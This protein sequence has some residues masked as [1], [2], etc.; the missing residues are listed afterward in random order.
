MD[1]IRN[2]H[3]EGS[4]DSTPARLTDREIDEKLNATAASALAYVLPNGKLYGR[5]YHCGDVLDSRPKRGSKG[6]FKFNISKLAGRDFGPTGEERGYAGVFSVYVGHHRG[7]RGAARRAA[8]DFLGLSETERPVAQVGKGSRG[9]G[10][11][12]TWTQI[13]PAP[14]IPP[15]FRKLVWDGYRYSDCWPYNDPS[16]RGLFHVLRMDQDVV[17]PETGEVTTEKV[18]PVVSFGHFA[19][20]CRHWRTKGAGLNILF[21]L[22]ELARR[23]HVPVL[24]VEGEKAAQVA[25]LLFPDWVVITWK[26]GCS[27]VGKIDFTP[28]KGRIVYFLADADKQGVAAMETAKKRAAA[29]GAV[30]TTLA[31]PPEAC[32]TAKK[33]WDLADEMPD[34]WTVDRMRDYI[35]T[36]DTWA[37]CGLPAYYNA[38][39]MPARDARRLQAKLI[40][41]FIPTEVEMIVARE[42]ARQRAEDESSKNANLTPAQKAQ[43][44]KRHK[45]DVA[46]MLGLESL[47]NGHRM[48][49]TGSQ[50]T[51]KSS[52]AL[53]A[54]AKLNIPWLRIVFTLPTVEKSWEAARQYNGYRRANSL[55]AY[56]VRGRGAFADQPNEQGIRLTDTR[57]CA[58]HK[59]VNRAASMRLSPRKTICPTCPFRHNCEALKQE[60]ELAEFSGGVFFMAREYVFLDLPVDNVHL[61]IGDESLTAVAASEPVYIDPLRIA[62]VGNWKSKGINAAVDAMAVLGSVHKAVTQHSG[63]ILAGCRELNVGVQDLRKVAAYL[64][65]VREEAVNSRVTGEMSD[66]QIET[67]LDDIQRLEFGS[68]SR[69]CRQLAIEVTQPR[70]QANTVCLR[71]PKD[72][73]TGEVVDRLAVFHLRKLR[74]SQEVPILLLDGTGSPWLNRKVFGDK[75]IHHHVPIERSAVVMSTLGRQFSRQ[76]VTG[77]DRNDELISEAVTAEVATLRR[78]IVSFAASL[79]QSVFVCAT[80]RAETA[81]E[82]EVAAAREAGVDI[83]TAHFA[84]VRGKN[85][86]QHYPVAMLIGREEVTPWAL[87]DMTRPFLGDD[88]ELLV[89][90]V[91]DDGRSCYVKQCRGRR[92]RDGTVVPVEVS[93]HPDPR[94]EDMHEQVREAELLQALD[95]VRAIYNH[96]TVYL[97]NHLVLDVTYD[98]NLSWRDMKAGGTRFDVA[99]E[100]TGRSVFLDAPGEWNRCFPD[101]WPTKNAAKCAIR[102][103][104]VKLPIVSIESPYNKLL[105]NRPPLCIRYQRP[106]QGQQPCLAW[107]CAPAEKACATLEKVVGPILDTWSIDWAATVSMQALPQVPAPL[108]GDEVE[109]DTGDDVETYADLLG[110]P[111]AVQEP[112]AP[113]AL[114]PARV[115]NASSITIRPMEHAAFASSITI[116][117]MEHAALVYVEP[118]EDVFHRQQRATHPWPDRNI[119]VH[120]LPDSNGLYWSDYEALL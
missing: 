84:D 35:V 82:A 89:P 42:T 108:R 23:P 14:A 39:A 85:R 44:T 45:R 77:T 38:P 114:S 30:R 15:D 16:G 55:P 41:E 104:G 56:V 113:P 57:M 10:A 106:G 92:M 94:C 73:D 69:L 51:G 119:K 9:H 13:F 117:P 96:R 31:T 74:V 28:L 6:S 120:E 59:T 33:G 102:E 75:L 101:L 11:D 61:L 7:D 12:E 110:D 115:A 112:V 48:L 24:V 109:D 26:G 97:L 32:W 87:E 63:S 47:R 8:L 78:D 36:S 76:S 2:R 4:A 66:E 71:H 27:N 100:R 86:W 83:A 90:S 72:K 91:D 34:G 54:I 37:A 68:V 107:V 17:D 21:G 88:P 99:F 29:A 46:R 64:D 58:R 118:E 49:I 65:D 3:P 79:K 43:I 22:D 98:A 52:D 105:G 19:D 95:R 80:M 67:I 70:H 111:P 60:A 81:L 103:G 62:E 40:S 53:K 93:V 20:G 50:G 18:T 5:E 25:R 1:S 116:R